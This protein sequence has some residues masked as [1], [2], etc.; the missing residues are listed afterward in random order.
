MKKFLITAVAT[1][2]ALIALPSCDE[3][4]ETTHWIQFEDGSANFNAN[5]YLQM[6]VSDEVHF[7]AETQKNSFFGTEEE[8]IVWFNSKMDYL[9]SEEFANSD[10][11]VPVLEESSA[12][13]SLISPYDG[14]KDEDGI[15]QGRKVTSRTVKFKEHSIL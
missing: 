10:P 8:A 5:L 1:A 3:I 4:V 14:E 2:V 11:V 13:F 6:K 9:E 7:D 12:T 15:S